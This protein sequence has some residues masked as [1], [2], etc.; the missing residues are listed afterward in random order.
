[1][2]NAIHCL[3]LFKAKNC[4]WSCKVDISLKMVMLKIR[5]FHTTHHECKTVLAHSLSFKRRSSIKEDITVGLQ[6]L[7]MTAKCSGQGAFQLLR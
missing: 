5:L 7:T 6:P 1:M 2:G 4:P 3:G